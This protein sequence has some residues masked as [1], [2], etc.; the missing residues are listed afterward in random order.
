MLQ[1]CLCGFL[2]IAAIPRLSYHRVEISTEFSLL[3]FRRTTLGVIS[4]G[5]RRIIPFLHI[6]DI[7]RYTGK[8]H[9][10]ESR[11]KAKPISVSFA[12]GHKGVGHMQTYQ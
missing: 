7:Y 10:R 5:D 2:V 6:V 8:F 11:N 4:V 3:V 12:V 1:V 9:G